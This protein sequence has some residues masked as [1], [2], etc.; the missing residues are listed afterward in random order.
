M[1][2]LVVELLSLRSFETLGLNCP[3]SSTRFSS[4][5]GLWNYRR[6]IKGKEL[7]KSTR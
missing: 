6:F 3:I 2:D 4:V 5:R 1:I 7:E